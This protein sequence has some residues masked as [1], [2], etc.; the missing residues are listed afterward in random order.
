MEEEKDC[1]KRRI[2]NGEWRSTNCF[3]EK[4]RLRSLYCLSEKWLCSDRKQ[5]QTAIQGTAQRNSGN[6]E[7]E[8]IQR[9]E[10]SSDRQI[11][12]LTLTLLKWRIG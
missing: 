6:K 8:Q 9:T 7:N 12:R 3:S 2:G 1:E 4:G 5:C 10:I 11:N